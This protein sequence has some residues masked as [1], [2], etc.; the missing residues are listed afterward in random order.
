MKQTYFKPELVVHHADLAEMMMLSLSET[1]ANPNGT[2][3]SR[4]QEDRD[5][6]GN[7]E[8]DEE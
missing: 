3:L 5:I 2:V 6:W 1:A 8:D 4:E 7:Y